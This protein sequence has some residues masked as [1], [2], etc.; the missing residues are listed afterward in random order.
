MNQRRLG[1]YELQERLRWGT[2]GETWKAFDTLHHRTVAVKIITVSS[3][4][5]SEFFQRF[6]QEG[7]VVAALSHPHIIQVHEFSIAPDQNEAYIVTDYV[8]GQSL[9]E[10]LEVTAHVGNLS[11][12]A[13][14]VQLLIPIGSALDYAHQCGVLH[15]ALSPA[16]ILLDK[17][18]G[19][20]SS[21]GEPILS[22]FGM[23]QKQDPRLL[24]LNDVSYIAPEVAQGYA[25]TSR[26]DLYSLGVIL[27]ELC[28]GTLPFQGE[29]ASEILLQHIHGTPVSPVLINPHIRPALTAAIIRSL[30]RD[31]AARFSSA[32]ALVSAVARAMN[33]SMPESTS[34]SN[35]AL[36]V[37][38]PVS[39]SAINDPNTPTYLISPP[40]S[41]SASQSGPM[42]PIVANSNAPALPP[43]PVVP[44]V[45]PVLSVMPTEAVPQMQPSV[46]VTPFS[47][48]TSG[49]YPTVETRGP[50][51][52]VAPVSPLSQPVRRPL[53]SLASAGKRRTGLV[54]LSVLLLAVLLGSG[55]LLYLTIIH[56]L[57]PSSQ[58]AI[59]G[60]AFFISSGL[61]S[62]DSNQGITDELRISLQ[63][64]ADPQSGK[65]Y[66]G[67]LK[68]NSGLDIPALALGP[69][70]VD[71]G[72]ITMTYSSPQHSNLLANY[73]RFLITEEEANQQPTNPSLDVQHVWRYY[74]AF[75]TVPS[76]TDPK[77]YSP[78][79]HLRHL[80]SQ[81]PKLKNVELS[82]GLSTWLFR[83]TTKI[84][85]A[86]GSARD[87][88]KGCIGSTDEGCTSLIFRQVARILDYLDGSAYVQTEN[89]PA[90]I[91]G[92]HLLIDPIIARVALLEFDTLH[93]EPPGY[94]EHIGGHLQQL[95]QSPTATPN[96]RA[97]ANRINQDINNV[98]GWLNAVHTDASTLIHMS[99]TQLLQPETLPMLND[100]FNQAN[101]AFVG[102]VD[103]NTDSVKEGVVQ[104]Y[105]HIQAL[106]TFDVAPCTINQG[107][108][109]CVEREN[110]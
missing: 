66:Y 10:Y 23:H 64:V 55:V 110:S 94:L 30:S 49:S 3:E 8:E 108:S 38:N 84:L 87:I 39:L 97:L 13:E 44:T 63:N 53:V 96:Q 58:S 98:Q 24:P 18:R 80:L 95:S 99:S 4:T 70:P 89:I 65:R 6:N 102:Q 69:L 105:Y 62:K 43:P 75:S 101:A 77:H 103:P 16:V 14:I 36:S 12:P 109:S 68:A 76:A 73:G 33:V 79:D 86:A 50:V 100:L 45:T 17:R 59:V 46:N 29:T 60:H 83:N 27:Y 85:E 20:A 32:T 11:P 91:Q 7:Q 93:Q 47:S 104:I 28:T 88:Q 2:I 19:T 81:D 61:I 92:D 40:S 72:Q 41:L 5:S 15:G 42:P 1:K 26:S 22:D 107:Q 52:V 21:A 56:P 51:P 35:P 78:L 90:N 34:Q 82:G 9:A 48:Q 25:G 106:A 31:P 71:H 37:I 57:L 54:V 67:W 74:S